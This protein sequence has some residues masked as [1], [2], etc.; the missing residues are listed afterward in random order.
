[1][2]KKEDRDKKKRKPKSKDKEARDAVNR[3]IRKDLEAA[4]KLYGKELE[5]PLPRLEDTGVSEEYQRALNI[6]GGMVD[7]TSEGYVGRRTDQQREALSRL[8]SEVERAQQRSQETRDIL[9]TLQGGLAGLN[10]SE[11]VA[12]REQAQREVDRQYQG[13][14]RDLTKAQARFGARGASAAAQLSN[15]QRQRMDTQSQLEQDLLVRNIDVQDRRR[16]QYADYLRALE[17]DE[18]ARRSLALGQ[19]TD[20]LNTLEGEEFGRK[21]G[22]LGQYS[23]MAGAGQEFRRAGDLYNTEQGV[24]EYLGRLQG[25]LG[26][27]GLAR[28]ER[29]GKEQLAALEKQASAGAPRY[30]VTYNQG[31]PAAEDYYNTVRGIYERQ[32][33]V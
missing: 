12:L 6:M 14:V 27:L 20:Q 11:N 1:M 7:P 19:Y 15:T 33:G 29:M 16:G 17:G 3:S 32:Y 31:S 18:S 2:A 23:Q 8:E 5:E 13:A 30:N 28:S 10:A 24:K 25:K 26:L 21:F 4:G 9:S 22:A